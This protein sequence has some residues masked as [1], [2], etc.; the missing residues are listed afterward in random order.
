MSFKDKIKKQDYLEISFKNLD[1]SVSENNQQTK[2]DD[3]S[4]YNS[5]FIEKGNNILD[6]KNYIQ[7]NKKNE[8]IY[9]F[10]EDK[11]ILSIYINGNK[12]L[13]YKYNFEFDDNIKINIGFPLDLVKDVNDDKFKIYSLIKIESFRIFLQDN[14]IKENIINIYQLLINKIGCDFLFADELTTFKLNE[15]TKLIS[16]YNNWYSVRFNSI[17]HKNFIKAQFHKKIFFTT[18]L[19]SN[20]LDYMLRFEKYIFILLNSLNIDRI[21][22]NELITLLCSYLF[23]N[24]N[25]IPKF[26]LK[27]EFNSSLYFSLYRNAKFIDKESIDNLISLI[28]VNNQKKNAI[29]NNNIIEILLDVKL[30]DLLNDQVKHDLINSIYNKIIQNELSNVSK[31]FIIEKLSKI[32]IL[33]MFN[34]KNDIDELIIRIIFDEFEKNKKDEKSL[35]IIEEIV[36]ILF[37]F[38]L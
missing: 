25:F 38:D 6:I 5:I 20:S 34:N 3:L 15:N 33:C 8:I 4:N 27:E 13:S 30:F 32:L 2:Y 7:I 17:F 22:F 1:I 35:S 10:K 18:I 21:I 24:E 14:D 36:Y 11:K 9:I 23:I 12:I 26:L 31:S 16:K 37:N 29:S 19:L 28:L